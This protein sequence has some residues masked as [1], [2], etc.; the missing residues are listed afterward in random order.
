MIGQ[1]AECDMNGTSSAKYAYNFIN[2]YALH[3]HTMQT[4][5]AIF[6]YCLY[7]NSMRQYLDCLVCYRFFLSVRIGSISIN[8]G[9]GAI[10]K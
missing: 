2:M 7:S 4:N 10:G 1:F 9:N 6:R 5:G 8:N 3:V